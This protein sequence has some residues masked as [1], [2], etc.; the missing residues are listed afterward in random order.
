[1]FAKRASFK[2]AAVPLALFALVLCLL[3]PDALHAQ[4]KRF[5][6]TPAAPELDAAALTRI[7]SVIQAHREARAVGVQT[8]S[9]GGRRT[10][11]AVNSASR[12]DVVYT[13]RYVDTAPAVA[14]SFPDEAHDFCRAEFDPT[15]DQDYT[16]AST[17]TSGNTLTVQLDWTANDGTVTDFDLF[18]F[19][20]NGQI[21][22][23]PTG[24]LPDGAYGD[25]SQL[26]GAP[27]TEVAFVTAS[28]G[29][30][31]VYA[32]V[33]RFRG[34]GDAQLTLSF[35]GDDGTFVVDE[36][37][38]DDFFT[39]IDAVADAVIGLLLDGAALDLDAVPSPRP[40]F[41]AAF[42]TDGCARSV[43]F[44]L[45]N[46]A[47]G[48][49][50]VVST[51]DLAPFAAL[52]DDAGDFTPFDLAGGSYILE[53]IPYGGP[54]GTGAAGT[55]L[56]VGFTVAETA[57]PGIGGFTLID[58]D[59]DAPV[60]GYDPIAEGAVLDLTVL[61]PNL[62]IRANAIDPQGVIGSV[63]MALVRSDGGVGGEANATDDTA[64][65]SVYGDT[66]GDFLPGGLDIGAY[67]LTGTPFAGAGGQGTPFDGA[68]LNFSVIGP[69]IES[70][71]LIDAGADA[72]IP[73][74]DPIPDGAVLN[75]AALPASLNIRANT[76]DPQ[77][78]LES[79]KFTLSLNGAVAR[80]STERARPY[81]LYGDFNQAVQG[82]DTSIDVDPPN[83]PN[84]GVWPSPLNGSYS[85]LG[86][87]YDNDTP[88][89]G[90]AYGPLTVNF[91]IINSPAGAAPPQGVLTNYPNPF[92][93]TTTIR[94]ALAEAQP[95]KLRV[96]DA[97]GREV[98]VLIDGTV[99]A[100]AHEVEFNAGTLA[101]GLYLYR[102]ETRAGVQVRPMVLMK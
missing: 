57:A 8:A 47:T 41:N 22:G 66:A 5:Q 70:Y 14:F 45:I 15:A 65:Y 1:M 79:V 39:H 81:S 28:G 71:T 44:H 30:E 12:L 61:P 42:N 27:P 59:T 84:Y 67:T 26:A 87:P 101:S 68:T 92:N 18:L 69:R 29:D 91:S 62:N 96:F 2:P 37:V 34:T 54:G 90:R 73:E 88:S 72:P 95:V 32:V 51:D 60:D 46:Q 4:S 97:V 9:K 80:T 31:P 52:G 36:Y 102:L 16:L 76:R 93:P 50:L 99:D 49:T 89:L 38:G 58:A 74:Y 13:A 56:S 17:L 53:A 33:D 3:A 86:I 82:T 64:P 48:D 24:L 21:V 6:D 85:L 55:P 23:D 7:Q 63:V 100:G 25:A 98:R 43:T 35:T 77:D 75:L 78:I 19:D 20:R 10:P 83:I 40:N 94:F 11:P